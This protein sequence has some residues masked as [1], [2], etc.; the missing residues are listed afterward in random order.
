MRQSAG[1]GSRGRGIPRSLTAFEAFSVAC[2]ALLLNAGLRRQA[3]IQC[4]DD[5]V[6][7]M[8]PGSRRIADVALYK[9]FE[10]RDVVVLEIGDGDHLR[11][12]GSEDYLRRPLKFGWHQI[13]TGTEVPGY[14]PMVLVSINLAKLRRCFV[15]DRASQQKPSFHRGRK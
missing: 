15:R 13:A 14:E 7:S 1:M 4:M 3:V 12:I 8:V 10:E 9:A 11:L 6:R 5:L 2:A